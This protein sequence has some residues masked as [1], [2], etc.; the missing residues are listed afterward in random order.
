VSSPVSLTVFGQALRQIRVDR[1]LLQKELADKAGMARPTLSVYER[2]RAE[3]KL[4][5][6]LRLLQ[7]M[8]AELGQLGT[9]MDT[10]T[11]ESQEVEASTGPPHVREMTARA[12]LHISLDQWADALKAEFRASLESLEPPTLDT[13]GAKE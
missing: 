11:P 4:L 5:S 9:Y 13:E 8:D 10:L 1:G 6:V 2:G 3:P 12:G 7:A